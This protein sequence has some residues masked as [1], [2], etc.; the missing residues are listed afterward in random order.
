[1]KVNLVRTI[2]S[3]CIS[4]LIA[5]G[6]YSFYEGSNKLLLTYG[7]FVCLSLTL[8]WS[9]GISLAQPRTTTVIR[10]ISGVFFAVILVSNLV[11]SFLNFTVPVYIIVNGI[12]LLLYI[13]TSYTIAKEKQ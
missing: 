7:S 6:F 10:T 4:A 8:F 11:F 3:I 12:I 13:L 1:M 5:Y 2:V 9:L